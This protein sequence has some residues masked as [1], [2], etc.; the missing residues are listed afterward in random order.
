VNKQ[1]IWEY[2]KGLSEE[3]K[4]L[5]RGSNQDLFK[6]VD[7]WVVTHDNKCVFNSEIR[8]IYTPALGWDILHDRNPFLYPIE[9]IKEILDDKSVSDMLFAYYLELCGISNGIFVS[10]SYT[11][12]NKC[13][14]IDGVCLMKDGVWDIDGHESSISDIYEI[15]VDDYVEIERCLNQIKSL[16]VRFM[17]KKK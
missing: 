8:Y 5:F 16:L 7:Q 14:Y 17:S 10:G 3:A 11:F 9:N 13:F 2:Y 6:F 12:V 1:D 4:F 15:S